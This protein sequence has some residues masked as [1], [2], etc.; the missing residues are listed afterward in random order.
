[1]ATKAGDCLRKV[2]YNK[3]RMDKLLS[4]YWEENDMEFTVFL[5]RI[6]VVAVCIFFTLG[7]VFY[8][9]GRKTK[10]YKKSLS[11]FGVYVVLNAIR[12][13]LENYM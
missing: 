13:V 7:V 11:C 10:S 5:D 4:D 8:S 2:D 9:K 12:L 1:M 3:I 6:L